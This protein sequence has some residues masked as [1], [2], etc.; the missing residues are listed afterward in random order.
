M[1]QRNRWGGVPKEFMRSA[2]NAEGERLMKMEFIE[3][4]QKLDEKMARLDMPEE[5]AERC[6]NRNYSGGEK[7]RNEILQVLMIE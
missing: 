3:L 2:I 7:K 4:I 1:I 5:M 6:L